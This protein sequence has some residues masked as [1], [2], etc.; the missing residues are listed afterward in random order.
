[1]WGVASS[2]GVL[3]TILL[4]VLVA[5]HLFCGVYLLGQKKKIKA[6]IRM[7]KDMIGALNRTLNNLARR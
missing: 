4:M 7:A 3:P 1:M 6:R 2:F 5:M